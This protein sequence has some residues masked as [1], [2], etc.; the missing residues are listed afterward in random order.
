M[1]L[2]DT[3]TVCARKVI[4]RAFKCIEDRGSAGAAIGQACLRNAV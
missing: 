4:D 3:D 2:D 1:E